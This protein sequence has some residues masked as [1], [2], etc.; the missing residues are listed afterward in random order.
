MFVYKNIIS[1]LCVCVISFSPLGLRGAPSAESVVK[2]C[3]TSNSN[4]S[5]QKKSRLNPEH[6]QLAHVGIQIG[7]GAGF[8]EGAEFTECFEHVSELFLLIS[9]D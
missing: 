9:F 6:I 8:G 7:E 1:L 2:E 4:T 5:M 3:G